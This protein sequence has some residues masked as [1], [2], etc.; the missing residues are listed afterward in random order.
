MASTLAAIALTPLLTGWLAGA[1]VEIDRRSLFLNMLGVV[2]VPVLAGV[3]FNRLLPGAVRHVTPWSPVL[4]VL[5]VVLIVGGINA[6]KKDLI[7]ENA[8]M[9]LLA[10]FLLHAGGFGLGYWLARWLGFPLRDARTV[11]IEVGMQNSGLGSALAST[12]KFQA[13]FTDIA[14]AAL[15]PVPS[16]ISALF[17]C[18]IGSFLAMRRRGRAA[19]SDSR[20][21][22]S[23]GDS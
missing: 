9:L 12:A 5:I 4:S 3:M 15:A 13:Q 8:G 7:R 23:P 10:V 2:L 16:A 1:F 6:A 21:A 18:L 11:S 20:I 22:D 17:H 19:Q 14:Q